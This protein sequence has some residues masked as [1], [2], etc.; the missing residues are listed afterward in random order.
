MGLCPAATRCRP[1]RVSRRSNTFRLDRDLGI[2]LSQRL[3]AELN[4]YRNEMVTINH[5]VFSVLFE[6]CL[7]GK[8]SFLGLEG[9]TIAAEVA[10]N[11]QPRRIGDLCAP[12]R[13][14]FGVAETREPFRG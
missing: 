4:Q 9:T 14:E 8:D 10:S 5:G 11:S 6:P 13:Y 7:E 12:R 1:P 3:P 2:P